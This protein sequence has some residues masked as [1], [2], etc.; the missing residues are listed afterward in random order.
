M[1]AY[2]HH[3]RSYG[4]KNVAVSVLFAAGLSH[5]KAFKDDGCDSQDR[6]TFTKLTDVNMVWTY[7]GHGPQTLG[8]MDPME[9]R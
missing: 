8:S 6:S 7:P 4:S 5:E 3:V 9:L 2:L 1:L